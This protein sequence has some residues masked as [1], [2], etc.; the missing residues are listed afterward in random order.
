MAYWINTDDTEREVCAEC[1]KVVLR[2][3]KG[4]HLLLD[5]DD[6]FCICEDIY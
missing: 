2:D 1:N 5:F 3:N 4:E 6:E